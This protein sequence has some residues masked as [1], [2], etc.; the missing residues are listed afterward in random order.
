MFSSEVS[1]ALLEIA[2]GDP[3]ESCGNRR[4]SLAHLNDRGS[5]CRR[6]GSIRTLVLGREA[7]RL[8]P[9]VKSRASV[10]PGRCPPVTGA[11][12]ARGAE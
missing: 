6:G 11:H 9:P 7:G 3:A 8:L 2:P 1:V 12:E 10:A 4:S 5:I